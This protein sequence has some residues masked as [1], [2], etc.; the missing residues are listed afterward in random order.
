MLLN[1]LLQTF[2]H[3]HSHQHGRRGPTSYFSTSLLTWR[4][5]KLCDVCQCDGWKMVTH[6]SSNLHFFYYNEWCWTSCLILQIICVCFIFC[7]LSIQILCPFALSPVFGFLNY[8]CFV[9]QWKLFI[10]LFHPQILLITY[11]VP[12][13]F[14]NLPVNRKDNGIFL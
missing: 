11:S 12:Y 1:C 14:N 4:S 7:E 8:F 10:H 9:P 13:C 3:F 5:D 2:H 6:R